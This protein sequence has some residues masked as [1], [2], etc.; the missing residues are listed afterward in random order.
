[1][2]ARKR[3]DVAAQAS[4]LTGMQFSQQLRAIAM[5]AAEFAELFGLPLSQVRRVLEGGL[6]GK[7]PMTFE[8]ALHYAERHGDELRRRPE[9]WDLGTNRLGY[10]LSGVTGWEIYQRLRAILW[11]VPDLARF[12]GMTDRS[13]RDLVHSHRDGRITV[14]LERIIEFVERHPLEMQALPRVQTP[15]RASGARREALAYMRDGARRGSL[16]QLA[17]SD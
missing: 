16:G 8:I 11:S 2:V 5:P 10:R 12:L 13:V 15:S 6:E 3:F 14:L 17:A 4:T 1:M 7:I 9:P